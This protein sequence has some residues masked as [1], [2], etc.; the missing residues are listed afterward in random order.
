MEFLFKVT[1]FVQHGT[2]PKYHKTVIKY[3]LLQLHMGYNMTQP[4]K[5]SRPTITCWT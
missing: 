4:H 5:K 3:Y 1:V 2:F